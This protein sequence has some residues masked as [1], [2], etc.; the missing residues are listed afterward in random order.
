MVGGTIGAEATQSD[1]PGFDNTE[2][3]ELYLNHLTCESTDDESKT[4][5]TLSINML[6]IENEYKY[7]LLIESNYYQNNHNNLQNPDKIH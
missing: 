6:Q 3:K 4:E 5:N 2:N 1:P 7:S